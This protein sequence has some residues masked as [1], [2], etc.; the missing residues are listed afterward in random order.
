MRAS[1][2]KKKS[3]LQDKLSKLQ[4]EKIQPIENE[5]AKLD[6]LLTALDDHAKEVDNY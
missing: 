4:I 2:E 6:K 5:I 1:I 3:K